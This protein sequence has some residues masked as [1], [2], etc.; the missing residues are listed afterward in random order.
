MG[1]GALRAVPRHLAANVIESNIISRRHHGPTF[2]LSSDVYAYE[3]PPRRRGFQKSRLVVRIERNSILRAA[4][5][6]SYHWQSLQKLC[7]I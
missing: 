3:I 7:M 2:G 5:G 4:G 6:N 1:T